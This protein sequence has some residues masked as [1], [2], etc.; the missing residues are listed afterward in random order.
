LGQTLC[1]KRTAYNP[2]PFFNSAKFFD[3]EYQTYGTVNARSSETE[4]SFYWEHES[5]KICLRAVYNKD[6][7]TLIGINSLGMRLR[8]AVCDKWLQEKR[9]I[10]D[11]LANL[12]QL[13]FDPEFF[14]RYENDILSAYNQK[15]GKNIKLNSKKTFS[16][17]S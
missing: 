16:F 12:H 13:N 4:T 8:H 6:D 11:V 3:I 2:G 17:L 10:D 9:N 15:S 7:G 1:G 5:G 14:T